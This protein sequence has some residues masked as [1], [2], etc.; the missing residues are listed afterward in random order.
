MIY[1]YAVTNRTE[2]AA[3]A[4]PGLEGTPLIS[5]T[6]RDIAAVVSAHGTTAG[7]PLTEANLRLHEAVM[8][9]LMTDRAVLPVRFGTLL[10]DEDA[11]QSVLAAHYADFSANLNRVRGRVEIGLRVLWDGDGSRSPNV[12][13]RRPLTDRVPTLSGR[14]YM[15]ARLEEE[16][17]AQAWN[18]RA[19]AL[20]MEIHKPLAH[21]ATESTQQVLV[22]PRLLLTA[23]YLI[24]RE[25]VAVLQ[26]EVEALGNTHPSLRLLC[27][28]P[29]PPYSFVTVNGKEGR[30]AAV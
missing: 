26:Q 15:L 14:S 2:A 22:T 24:G 19:K 16:R 5:Q 23:A 8:E 28:G 29:W 11:V 21:L 27:T 9:T 20:A 6:C 4:G 10:A 18:R 1:L 13:G 3:P 12:G 7:V 30:D 25:Q 17:R